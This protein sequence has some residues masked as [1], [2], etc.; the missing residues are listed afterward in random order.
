M[1]PFYQIDHNKKKKAS[2]FCDEENKNASA[3][4][5]PFRLNLLQT[6]TNLLQNKPEPAG[7]FSGPPSSGNLL[8]VPSATTQPTSNLSAASHTSNIFAASQSSSLLGRSQPA[9]K[10]LFGNTTTT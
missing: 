9:S 3:K 6:T 4:P 5:Q 7:L 1:K 10:P 2:I 8:S